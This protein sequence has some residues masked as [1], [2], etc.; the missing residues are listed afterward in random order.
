MCKQITDQG[1]L[2]ACRLWLSQGPMQLQMLNITPQGSSRIQQTTQN[3]KY[4]QT[5][6]R[7]QITRI[8]LIQSKQCL[9]E[10]Q[11]HKRS[12]QVISMLKIQLQPHGRGF[13]KVPC[14][15]KQ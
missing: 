6:R 11:K 9:A 5:R 4:Y 14:Q 7:S 13:Q 1:L 8:A 3:C 15:K 2:G 12:G 10:G